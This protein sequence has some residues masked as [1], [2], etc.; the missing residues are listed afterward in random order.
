MRKAFVDTLTELA[1]KDDKIVLIVGDVGFSYIEDFAEKFPKQYIN[2]GVTEQSFMG[3]AAGMAL[4]G[5]KP[6]VYSMIPFVTMRNYEQLRNDVCYHNANVKVIGVRGSVHYK[7][8]GFSH[9]VVPDNE[10]ELILK[11]LPNLEIYTPRDPAEAR[12]A[13]ELSYRKNNPVYIRI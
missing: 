2:A 12:M 9:N 7:F 8:L 13:T 10:D 1:E 11:H 3:M 6:Y 4:A 5:W